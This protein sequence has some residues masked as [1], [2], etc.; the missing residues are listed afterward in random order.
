MLNFGG[1]GIQ[2]S[3]ENGSWTYLN[4]NTMRFERWLN[5]PWSS[6]ENMT[7]DAI[8]DIACRLKWDSKAYS[9]IQ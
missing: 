4:L 3:F 9:N 8:Q 2:S 7:I 5:T 6:S 1:V